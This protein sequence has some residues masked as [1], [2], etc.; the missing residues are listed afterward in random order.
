M[1]TASQSATKNTQTIG[2]TPFRVTLCASLILLAAIS[3]AAALQSS[4][5]ADAARQ[6]R[7][8]KQDQP[9]AEDSQA[10]QV[11]NQLVEDQDDTGNAP[12]GFKTY[13]AGDYKLWVPAPFTVEGH[14]ASGIVLA[15]SAQGRARAL[16]LVGNPLV[17][18]TAS[19]DEAFR[20]MASKFAHIY[21]QTATCTQASVEKR[22]AYQCG[23][24]GATLLGHSVS[25][26]AV[27]VRGQSN[28]VPVF[29][30]AFTESR[31][32][33][34]LN[35]PQSNWSMKKWARE[36]LAREDQQ[37][38]DTWHACESVLQSIRLKE[39]EEGEASTA[40]AGK[41]GRTAAKPASEDQAQGD[42]GNGDEAA[43]L[44]DVARRLHGDP[45]PV[46]QEQPPQDNNADPDAPPEGFKVHYF[47]YCKSNSKDCWDAQV[48]VPWDAKLL[49]S[50]CKQYVYET[51]V[52]GQPFLLLVGQDGSAGCEEHQTSGPDPVR[53]HQLVD[54][55][56]LRA[57]GSASIISS[58]EGTLAGYPA[59]ITTLRF[60]KTTKDGSTDWM[61]KRGDLE[62]DG[63]KLVV[64]CMGPREHFEKGDELCSTLLDSFRLP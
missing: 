26:N 25:G 57:P 37:V 55:E 4:S 39:K 24:A 46:A 36:E 62:I 43:P 63:I 47:T 12:G 14:D 13:N 54:P 50:S 16:V 23:L 30:V 27:F 34:V 19:G 38:R 64:G 10:Q 5:L 11:V 8:Q 17:L 48:F 51:K 7:A 60:R 3:P 49:S 41:A 22:K 1:S 28:I 6:A 35:D 59:L 44:A 61:A 42:P 45:V 15:N 31:A 18:S 29:C 58:L 56:N 53:W 2:S 52:S 32:R 9:R 20:D 33:D 21:A 40:K